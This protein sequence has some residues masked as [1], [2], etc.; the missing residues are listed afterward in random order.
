MH[1][2]SQGI[3]ADGAAILKDGQPMTI[4]QILYELRCADMLAEFYVQK[5]MEAIDIPKGITTAEQFID[6]VKAH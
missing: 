1:D 4:E 5:G 6:W 2:Y 3:C